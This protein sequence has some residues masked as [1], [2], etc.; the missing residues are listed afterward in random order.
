MRDKYAIETTIHHI[1]DRYLLLQDVDRE[2]ERGNYS[3]AKI[4]S[5]INDNLEAVGLSDLNYE[6]AIKR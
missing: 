1:L 5:V 6:E 3:V 2:Y 4:L